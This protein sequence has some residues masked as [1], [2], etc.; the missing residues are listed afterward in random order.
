MNSINYNGEIIYYVISKRG[1]KN[2]YARMGNDNVLKLSIPYFVPK[3]VIEK[4]VK[5]SY[6][7]LIKKKQ[8]KNDTIVHDGK[9]RVIEEEYDIQSIENLNYLLNFKLKEYLR[10]NYLDICTRLSIIKPP[11]IVLKRVKGYLGQYNKK[12]H[13]IT[14]NTLIGHL[15][16]ECI[17]YVL[18]HELTHIKYMNHQKEFWTEVERHLP[19]YKKI[20]NKCKK[21]FVYYENY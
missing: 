5:D 4:F 9:I 13:Q 1:T 21:E 8:T 17:E 18:I 20:R 15:D 6:L 16:K 19:K 14:L 7:K 11:S 2:L 12:L 3:T 10:N